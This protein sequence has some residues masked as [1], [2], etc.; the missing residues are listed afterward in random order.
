MS[1]R[2]ER[3]GKANAPCTRHGA[4]T[5]ARGKFVSTVT[6]RIQAGVS[7]SHTRP[8]KPSPAAKRASR[9]SSSN[10][11]AWP[12]ASGACQLS[13]QRM[14]S[15]P[16]LT[17]HSAPNRH[18]SVPPIDS[19]TRRAA[20]PAV[21]ASLRARAT[22]LCT[23]RRLSAGAS[24]PPLISIDPIL[25]TRL[26]LMGLWHGRGRRQ[27]GSEAFTRPAP[28]GYA[29][30]VAGLIVGLALAF[31]ALVVVVRSIR[32]VPQA[33][34]GIVERLGRYHRTLDPGLP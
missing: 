3:I 21:V 5:A 26:G 8:G 28:R 18:P 34:A 23:A 1:P 10:G 7:L 11:F 20:S 9:L 31:F 14:L 17:S 19:S 27:A 30:A 13:M 2:I 16:P 4:A 24:P 29:P 25:R 33:R 12:A 22:A 15:P 6:S 32:I